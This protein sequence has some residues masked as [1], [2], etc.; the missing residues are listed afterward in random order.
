MAKFSPKRQ[1]GNKKNNQLE[2]NQQDVGNSNLDSSKRQT[3]I[4]I[5]HPQRLGGKDWSLKVKA[6]VW[7]CAI[8]MLPLLAVG[9]ATYYIGNQQIS[10]QISHTKQ[11][12]TK[13][14]TE[15]KLAL[16]SQ[17][18]L[19]LIGTGIT[20]LLVGAIAALLTNRALRPLLNAAALSNNI[21]RRLLPEKAGTRNSIASKDELLVL[22]KN[23][24]LIKKQLPDLLWKQELVAER[25]QV[26][27]NI[28]RSIQE[29]L[30]EEDVLKTTVE[31]V[32]KALNTDRVTIF[33][34]NPNREG[35]FVAESVGLG[36]PKALRATVSVPCVG[37]EDIEKYQNGHIVA[38]DD[39][40]Q[41]DLSDF[42]L[43]F[44]ER[45][46]VKANLVAPIFKKDQLFGLLIAHECSKP[47]FWQQ[48]EIDLFAQIATQLG[49]VLNYTSLL[50]QVENKAD[51][52]QVF[53]DIIRRIRES[54]NEEDVLK[55]TVEEVR[56]SLS[57]DR[58]II[59]GFDPDWYGTVIA[60]SV[61]PGFPKAL[62]ARIKDPCF[63]EGYVEK[64]QAGRV[65]AIN[66]IYA[67]GLTKCHISQ[68]EPFA[69]KANLVAPILKDDQLFGLL[70]AHECSEPRDWR[71]LEIDLFAQ[72]AMQ[73]GFAL[74]HA[75]LL[76]RIDAEGVRTQLLVDITRRIRE[77]LN[78]EDVLKTTVEEVR[79]A[80]SA[81]RVI[82]YGFDPDWYGTVIAESVLPGF[83]KALRARIKDP[84]FAEG[85]VEKYQAGR[86]QAINNIYAA[87]L[88]KCH[89][90]Q[91]E[92]FAVKA[93]LVAPILKDDQLFG[94][95]IAHEC[96]EP[97][98]WRQLEIDL[99]AQIA[100]QV[101]FALDH[102]RLL[103]QVDQAYQAAAATSVEQSQK[104]EEQRLQLSE[105]LRSSN[106]VVQTLSRDVALTQLQYI[107]FIYNQMQMLD[108]STQ[109][110][111]ISAQQL[112]L[113]EQQLSQTVEDENQ[114]MNQILDSIY[115]IQETVVQAA[116]K[117]NRL[118]EPSQKLS[119][120]INLMSNVISQIKLQAMHTG[121]EASRSGEAGQKFAA[122]AQKALSLVQQLESEI[123][124]IQPLVAEIYIENYEV[125]AAIQSGVE[126]AKSS[127]EWVEQTQQKFQQAIAL[128]IQMQTL[129]AEIAQAAAVQHQTSTSVNQSILEVASIANQTSE[130]AIALAESLAQLAIFTQEM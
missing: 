5:P 86:V 45:F 98:D 92:P 67:A 82:V 15:T 60:E 27:M 47:R 42:H 31:E 93:N 55:T 107:N 94:L 126:Q 13:D 100:M 10:E 101:G 40:Y 124:E 78:E 56:K 120:R 54:L 65:Q 84:C 80:I 44:L 61:L 57:A 68:L 69:V 59:Y 104:R 103:N 96:S 87:G 37:K 115:A 22:E 106:T 130:Q 79:K 123:T 122:I 81:D 51:Q 99:F 33:R 73:V 63:A 20:A 89:I 76:Q 129:V 2:G 29:C 109:E 95:L 53:V 117:V 11:V 71:Q 77:S 38:I 36:L 25:V 118:E 48:S 43:D 116:E 9:A 30:N 75:R 19:L 114:S 16:E 58:V 26:L 23:I 91:L 3:I 72:I 34:F 97:R 52:T 128:S 127:G 111:V 64:Y 88:T 90:S 66:N 105:M 7:S 49:F 62:R 110:M 17:L 14:L 108:D 1:V 18:S 112:E 4:Q 125:I 41:A 6:T 8:S 46:A 119:E 50:E 28:T 32:R 102:A 12:G 85:Y 21:V 121:L 113:Q 83:P 39:I 74:D 70:I 35:T 24:S